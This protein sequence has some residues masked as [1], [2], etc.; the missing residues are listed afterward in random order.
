M[1]TGGQEERDTEGPGNWC[2]LAACLPEWTL[3]WRKKPDRDVQVTPKTQTAYMV[4]RAGEVRG[5]VHD[6]P[7]FEKCDEV[8]G[9]QVPGGGR[10][11]PQKR[12]PEQPNG[13]SLQQSPQF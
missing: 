9:S 10:K 11:A 1:C 13:C 2:S 6:V 3:S 4:E 7:S 12:G 5:C 8:C